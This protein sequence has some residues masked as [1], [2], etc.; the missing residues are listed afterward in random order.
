MSAAAVPPSVAAALALS[1]AEA[2]ALHAAHVNSTF[3]KALGLLRFGRRFVRAEGERLWDDTGR[4]YWDFLA[5][6]GATPLGHNPP[7][8]RAAIEAVLGHAIPHFLLVSPQPLAA[9]LAARLARICPGDLSVSY[10]ASS[11][12]EAVEGALKLARAATGRAGFVAATG[13]YHG[14][15]FGALSVSDAGKGEAIFGPAVPGCRRVPWGDAGAIEEALR[16]GDVAAVLLEP[17]QGEGGVRLPPPGYLPDVA[18]L[19]RQHGTLFI[20][21]EVQTGLGRT[22]RMFACEHESVEPDVLLLAKGL[23][24]GLVPVSAYVTQRRIWEKAYGTLD[25]YDLHCT[26]F[27]GGPLA[28]AAALATL[29]EIEGRRLPARAAEAGRALGARLAQVT[30]GH[31]LVQAVRGQGLLWGLEVRPAGGTAA[32]LVGQW[33]AVALLERG[34]LTQVASNAPGVVRVQPPLTVSDTALDAFTQALGD[35]LATQARGPT[36][37]LVQAV[38]RVVGATVA[39]W[40]AA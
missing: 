25:R 3:V 39:G 6:Y 24:G 35:A 26:T 34:V 19:C 13:G 32:A 21:D 10:F 37:A 18:R 20:L 17:L 22:G 14:T 2:E 8:V 28:C 5:G 30:D 12:S 31:P 23:S 16:G 9:A 4:A 7:A 1:G 11:G 38:G 40:G 15:T 29:D 33:L 27:S 36:S